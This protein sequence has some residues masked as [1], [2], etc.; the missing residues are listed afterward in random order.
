M[1]ICEVN[2]SIK[3]AQMA[4]LIGKSIVASN[5]GRVSVRSQSGN[6]FMSGTEAQ[7]QEFLALI[8]P[9]FR[10]SAMV[11]TNVQELTVTTKG[12]ARAEINTKNGSM[13][14][15]A[16]ED[17]EASI[18]FS[19][20]NDLATGA[21]KVVEWSICMDRSSDHAAI[22]C[23]HCCVCGTCQSTLKS[24]PICR[25]DVERWQRVYLP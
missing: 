20:S 9:E 22:P 13:T 19:R 6:F 11:R 10:D 4:H 18:S 23:G 1:T 14:L 16:N 15:D 12:N 21:Q 2:I 7:Q 17:G 25:Q 3:A 24:C 5:G 8:S